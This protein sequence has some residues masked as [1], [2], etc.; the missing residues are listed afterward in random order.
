MT[1]DYTN[2][3][4]SNTKA[5]NLTESRAGDFTINAYSNPL[6]S[7]YI[8]TSATF[9]SYGMPL[10]A[11]DANDIETHITYG[12][13][14]SFSDLYPTQT[15]VAYGTSLARTTTATF[16]FHTGVV[17]STT[18]EDN[19]ITNATEYDD[20]GRPIK[21]I[22]A[23]GT[24]LESWTQSVYD[25]VNRRIVVKADLEAVGD[26]RQVATQFFD[27]LGRVRLA[28]TLE[29]ASTQSAT[30][31]TDGIKVQ[32]RYKTASG[33]TYQLASNP[34]R[35]AT[36]SAETDATMGWTL[37]TSWSSGIRAE[38]QSFSGAGLPTVFGG[39]NTTSTGIV[40]TDI[41]A[42]ATTVTDQ[43][44]KVH[45]SITNGIGQLIRVEEP[46]SSNQ[47]GAVSTPNQ[48]TNYSYNTLG[49]MV[50]VEQGSQNR[51]FMYD[52]LGRTLRIR[53]PEQEVNTALNT[54]GDPY[55]NSWTGGFTYDNNGNVLTTTDAKGTTIPNTYD[56]KEQCQTG[57]TAIR[58]K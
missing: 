36:S 35:A 1:Y 50:R 11:T 20:L 52:S 21:S 49:K 8:S 9:N 18:D 10:T 7:N 22:T 26:A 56:A 16:D 32:T 41:D 47:L 24:A 39:S 14:G 17:L 58:C 54:S 4:S 45:R 55:N 25:D 2:Y 34:Y 19:D 51:Y 5:G 44:S 15:V 42:N 3:G 57:E 46:N 29:D 40:R 53:Q 37:S 27:Q 31:E 12:S 48:A 6:S 43:A 30:N 13:I 38:T 23:Q 33:Y 28:K